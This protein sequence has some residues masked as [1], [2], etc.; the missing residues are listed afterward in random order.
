MYLPVDA[1]PREMIMSEEPYDVD[2]THQC[3]DSFQ[4][5]LYVYQ[6]TTTELM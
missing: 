6:T 3:E 1:M 5:T 2:I 4:T